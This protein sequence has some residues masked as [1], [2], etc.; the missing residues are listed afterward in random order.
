[1][2]IP[3]YFSYIIKNHSNIIR[4]LHYHQNINKTSFQHL[5]I[6]ANSIIY[7]AVR[8]I[9]KETANSNTMDKTELEQMIIKQVIV[10]IKKYIVFI[11]PTTT[12]FI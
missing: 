6:D 8:F 5:Y 3:S 10:N 9:E 1:M 4:N 2:G 11:K 12:I 7:D